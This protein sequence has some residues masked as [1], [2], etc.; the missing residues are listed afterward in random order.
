MARRLLIAVV[1]TAAW[2]G[3]FSNLAFGQ[4][5]PI[6]ETEFETS[7][8]IPGQ[9]VILRLTVLVPTWMSRPVEFPTFEVPNVRARLPE[10]ATYP[11]SRN[12]NGETWSGVVRTYH[13]TPL[14][15]GNFMIPRKTL[16]VTYANPGGTEPLKA[17]LQ[18]EPITVSGVV[19]AGAESL[20]PFIAASKLVLEQDVSEQT[21]GLSPGDSVRRTVVAH[22]EGASPFSLPGLIPAHHI[23][24][25]AAYP[26]QPVVEE[27]EDGETLS[28]TRTESL[29]LM[30]EVGGSGSAPAI[31]LNWYNLESGEIETATARAF[32]VAVVAPPPPP[33]RPDY[34]RITRNAVLMA[35]V[36]FVLLLMGKKLGPPVSL[37]LERRQQQRLA[38][39][40]WAYRQ[41]RNSIRNR[42]YP[43]TL[44]AL[45]RWQH[46][47]GGK[48][49]GQEALVLDALGQLGR[50]RYGRSSENSPVDAWQRLAAAVQSL[51]GHVNHHAGKPQ[52]LS[53]LNP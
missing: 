51:R 18:T 44:R 30:A 34:G 39:E 38:S 41:L 23:P 36:A 48:D 52:A 42:D 31:E 32:D 9:S 21:T 53:R 5:R 10:R 47:L 27:N 20:R 35:A 49:P 40:Q 2:L 16:V 46:R 26:D 37:W 50:A 29:T 6:L 15:P 8:A 11:T 3:L 22:I 12:I 33:P 17:N 4:D 25:I 7:Q 13:L 14:V 24:G 43:A 28:G 19:P 45:E 1:I